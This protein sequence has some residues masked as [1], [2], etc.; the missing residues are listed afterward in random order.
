MAPTSLSSLLPFDVQAAL[1]R[2]HA[3][4]LRLAGAYAVG[5][6][7]VCIGGYVIVMATEHIAKSTG[8]SQSFL[9]FTLVAFATS[10]PEV[11][12]TIAASRRGL[13]ITAASNI[14]GSNSFDVSLLL[15]VALVADG[16]MFASAP[17]PA[18][19]ASGLGI[20]LTAIYLVGML[21]RKDKTV[22]RMGWDSALVLVLGLLGI[23]TMYALG[24]S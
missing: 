24:T 19:F 7:L 5:S 16:P 10:L 15:L 17:I 4:R 11:S 8:A 13:G 6:L 3:T 18:V 2:I 9:G 1:Q 23:W 22:L 12:T 21:E 14:F 20:V